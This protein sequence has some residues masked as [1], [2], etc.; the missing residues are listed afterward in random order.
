MYL[1]MGRSCV[2][3]YAHTHE[4]RLS[5]F[6]FVLW[7]LSSSTSYQNG[8]RDSLVNSIEY[9]V[10][11]FVALNGYKQRT[12]STEVLRLWFLVRVHIS[13]KYESSRNQNEKPNF[14]RMEQKQHSMRLQHSLTPWMF[15][16]GRINKFTACLLASYSIRVF[17]SQSF[18]VFC[19]FSSEHCQPNGGKK[20]RR[21]HI[22]FW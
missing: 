11:L 4:L 1:E 6:P 21:A 5:W 2:F 20:E 13:L 3:V 14:N 17:C 7:S 9:W 8:N 15:V 22:M 18:T 10:D 12:H 19:F 16:N